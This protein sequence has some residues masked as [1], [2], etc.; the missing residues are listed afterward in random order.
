M[1]FS[2]HIAEAAENDITDSFF[3]YESQE[4][5][6]GFRFKN[7]LE[8]SILHIQKHPTRFPKKTSLYEGVL[9]LQFPLRY[10]FQYRFQFKSNPYCCCFSYLPKP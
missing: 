3:W 2:V 4:S 5:G 1:G 6:L 7:N 9:P 10:P 8:Q